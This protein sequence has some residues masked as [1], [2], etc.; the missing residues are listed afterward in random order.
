VIA[1]PG[2]ARRN[3]STGLRGMAAMP[4]A[5]RA[6]PACF[7]SGAPSPR[8]LVADD[9]PL[10]RRFLV[11]ALQAAGFDVVAAQDGIEALSFFRAHGPFDVVLL[12]EEM[13]R[14]S[15]SQAVRALRTAGETLPVVL[16]SGHLTLSAAEQQALGVG[17]VVQK[18]C[19]IEVLVE[20]LCHALAAGAAPR[21]QTAQCA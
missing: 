11:T 10:L 1:N 14:L 4:Q 18:P 15:G 17:S 13:P 21:S 5:S 16:F 20:A 3:P 8:I 6:L 7:A 2:G 12:D 19:G 9:D